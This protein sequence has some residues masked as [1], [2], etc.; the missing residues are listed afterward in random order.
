MNLVFKENQTFIEFYETNKESFMNRLMENGRNLFD[1]IA[2]I[3]N[4]IDEEYI[5][6][7]AE[8]IVDLLNREDEFGLV[9]HAKDHGRKWAELE[10][11]LILKLD[12]IQTLRKTYWDYL[13]NYYDHIEISKKEIFEME[14]QV[15]FTLDSYIKHFS[16]SFSEYTSY[17]ISA[18]N[19]LIDD[20]NVPVIPLSNEIAILPIIGMV[21][22]RRAKNIQFKV[23]EEIYKQNIKYIILDLSGVSYMDTAVLS[24]LFNIVNGIRIQGCKTILTGVRPEITNTIVELGIDLNG[25]VETKGTL[26]QALNDLNVLS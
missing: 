22:T 15:N 14:R 13:Y 12:W 19:E 8:T 17:L 6:R 20:L 11:E 21:D 23:L 25:K 2:G 7:S 9:L 10:F 5:L 24:H 3:D 1:S 26:Q 16:A 18:Q 4:S